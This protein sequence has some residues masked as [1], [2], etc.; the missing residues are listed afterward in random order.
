MNIRIFHRILAILQFDDLTLSIEAD[1]HEG[2][3]RP[4]VFIAIFPHFVA[5]EI[6]H[7]GRGSEFVLDPLFVPLAR[8]HPRKSFHAEG[9]VH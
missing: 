7:V 8:L 3:E 5:T 4:I 1:A 2:V 6:T 9:L